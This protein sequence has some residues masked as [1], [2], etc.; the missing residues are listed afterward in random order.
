MNIGTIGIE[1][2]LE[3][4]V[5][6]YPNPTNGQLWIETVNTDRIEIYDLQ[7]KLVFNQLV[8]D[9]KSQLDL[10]DIPTGIYQIHLLSDN[11]RRVTKIVK[12]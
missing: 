3:Q 11:Q 12:Q 4:E 9:N 1:E 6:A 8:F 5:K 7:G 2:N 10:S